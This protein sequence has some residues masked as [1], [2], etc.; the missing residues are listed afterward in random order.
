MSEAEFKKVFDHLRFESV[1]QYVAFPQLDVE[2]ND[3]SE[4]REGRAEYIQ[5][6]L[7]IFF[8]WL[9]HK[10]QGVKRIIRV[11]VDDFEDPEIRHKSHSDEGIEQALEG[12]VSSPVPP[13]LYDSNLT[14]LRMSRY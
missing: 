1:L 14:R 10:N 12:F 2:D 7:V 8:N 11:V 13:R 4:E 3:D 9:R 5:D 6:P